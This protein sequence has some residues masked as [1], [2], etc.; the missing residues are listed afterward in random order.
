MFNHQY[1]YF[2]ANCRKKAYTELIADEEV[3]PQIKDVVV[4]ERGDNDRCHRLYNYSFSSLYQEL[5]EADMYV[6]DILP[7]EDGY[8][9]IDTHELRDERV[10]TEAVSTVNIEI[11]ASNFQFQRQLS[12]TG[13]S[14]CIRKQSGSHSIVSWNS[15]DISVANN[16]NHRLNRQLSETG[17]SYC[18]TGQLTPRDNGN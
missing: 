10:L 7:E 5:N 18:M 17:S 16:S 1:I 4:N 13:S 2:T 12:D 6:Y 14:Y 11:L 9:Q 8:A 15:E 3:D